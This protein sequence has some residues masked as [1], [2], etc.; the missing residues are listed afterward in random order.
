MTVRLGSAAYVDGNRH[1]HPAVRRALDTVASDAGLVVGGSPSSNSGVAGDLADVA[2]FPSALTGSQLSA[3]FAASGCSR[4][5]APGSP[6]ATAGAN[7][8]TVSWSAPAAL[9][10]PV[11][12]YLVTALVGG[13]TPANSVS[14]AAG[15]TSAMVT[16]LVGGGSYRFRVQALNVYGAGAAATTSSV[17]P[18][19]SA[20]TYAS[21]V[22]GDHPSVFYR[23]DDGSTSAMADSSGHGA[24]GSYDA[25]NVTLGQAGP[26]ASDPAT[27]V[28]T[29]GNFAGQGFPTL[30]LYSDSRT[31]EGWINTTS[32]GF[33]NIAGYGTQ[34]NTEA[35][36]VGLQPNQVYVSGY[37]DSLGF[38]S[39]VTLDDGNW[40]FIVVTTNRT[41]ATVYVDGNA[42]GTQNLGTALD[43]LPSSS[44]FIVGAAPW[45]QGFAGDLA[46]VAVF[47]SALSAAQVSAQYSTGTAGPFQAQPDLC[48]PGALH[49]SPFRLTPEE[50]TRESSLSC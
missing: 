24:T 26:L 42:V 29:N 7:E 48:G 37:N 25:P 9:T 16:G 8:A 10:P 31:L 44:G 27:S 20:S 43:T 46:D 22:L 21:T 41:S 39:P 28:A 36:A 30:P 4:S 6:S 40:H 12:S 23:L 5:G 1:R 15:S 18:T 3:Q 33:G 17:T 13:A 2:V 47:P 11:E 19:G 14:V 34:S 38:T 49:L 45:G 35:F 32:T 50:A